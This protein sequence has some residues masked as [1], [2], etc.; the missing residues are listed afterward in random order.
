MNDAAR[1]WLID[2]SLADRV[3]ADIERLFTVAPNG[4]ETL[5]AHCLETFDWRL[6]EEGLVLLETFRPRRL[7]LSRVHDRSVVAGIRLGGNTQ[8]NFRQDLPTGELRERLQAVC[9]VRAL[10]ASGRF[11]ETR[12][13]FNLLNRDGKTVC[14]IALENVSA[15]DDSSTGFRLT[16]LKG[17]ESEAARVA[18]LLAEAGCRAGES[19]T[20]PA[21]LAFASVGRE[22]FD[23][24]SKSDLK[25]PPGITAADACRRI[26]LA[27]LDIAERNLPGALADLDTEFLHDF[28]VAL[29]RSRSALQLVKGVFPSSVEKEFLRELIK[30]QK[31]TNKLRDLD[32]HLIER[33][34]LEALLPPELQNGLNG[35]FRQISKERARAFVKCRDFL[36][37]PSTR[38]TL[39][40]WRHFLEKETARAGSLAG[41]PAIKVGKRLLRKRFERILRDGRAIGKVSPDKALHN[42]R[43]Q[44]KKLR[45]LLEFFGSLL[46]PGDTAFL[47]RRFRKLQTILG[48]F[49]DLATQEDWARRRLDVAEG[50]KGT[51]AGL[52]A[53]LGGLLSEL[54]RARRAERAKFGKA[55][56]ALDTPA[57]R[58]R[59][60]ILFSGKDRQT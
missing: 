14:R 42:L 22:P 9:G 8:T 37:R 7:I 30:I 32:V 23:Y 26:H 40:Q 41:K 19:W 38:N 48:R 15:K 44:F 11:R 13:R 35:L 55:F 59:A 27:S 51:P 50:K 2:D 52:A 60:D 33:D 6:L 54:A 1:C 20:H 12:K 21:S 49:N 45:Y 58:K 24:S 17:Y 46:P 47:V 57:V 28:R 56:A 25:L 16:P 4:S 36:K 43:I 5:S 18:A 31:A 10:L 39:A 29:R 53:S 34:A 3:L